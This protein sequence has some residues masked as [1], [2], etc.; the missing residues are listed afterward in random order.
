M[1]AMV[2]AQEMRGAGAKFFQFSAQMV[3][4][5]LVLV[6]A[7]SLPSAYGT[8]AAPESVQ[9][10]RRLDRAAEMQVEL[11]T[12]IVRTIISLSTALIAVGASLLLAFG[13]KFGGWQRIDA[14]LVVSWLFFVLS[15]LFGNGAIQGVITNL[16]QF[17]EPRVFEPV[18]TNDAQLLIGFFLAGLLL[19]LVWVGTRVRRRP[20]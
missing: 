2:S 12:E 20:S 14:L 13:E 1:L 11:V 9:L 6:I 17:G 7:Q 5:L 19:F 3:V 4:G 15:I 10:E 16:E 8:G 18:V